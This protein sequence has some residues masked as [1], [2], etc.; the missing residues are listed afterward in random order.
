[1]REGVAHYGRDGGLFPNGSLV[2][3]DGVVNE[4]FLL[5]RKYAVVILWRS[6][7]MSSMCMTTPPIMSLR[8][9]CESNFHSDSMDP[10][11]CKQ[12]FGSWISSSGR[13][14]ID[15]TMGHLKQHHEPL[16]YALVEL[17][18]LPS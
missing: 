4:I 17:G 8:K 12:W 15:G 5:G 9:L 14:E 1:M 16:Y 18:S 6:D 7:M 11:L 3:T 13:N 10:L 2:D